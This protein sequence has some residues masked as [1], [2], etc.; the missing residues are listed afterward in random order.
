MARV[1]LI[2][3]VAF[4]SVSSATSV[5]ATEIPDN[6]KDHM[7]RMVGSWT[8]KGTEGTRKFSG[9]EKIRLTN[10]HTALIQEGFFN[11]GD[12]KKE[13]YVILSGWDGDKKTVLVRGF[14]SEGYTWKGEWKKLANGKWQGNASGKPASFEVKADAMRYEDSANGSS[15]VSEFR[16]IKDKGTEKED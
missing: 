2:F 10:N 12:G 7:E 15:W 13:H 9:E 5:Q 4:A 1:F 3:T 16:R 14:T 8:F 11:L 6:V